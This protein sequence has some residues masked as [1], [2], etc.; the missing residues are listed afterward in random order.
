MG[1]LLTRTLEERNCVR[2]YG[3]RC[4]RLLLVCVCCCYPACWGTLCRC[5]DPLGSDTSS[6]TRSSVTGFICVTRR[7]IWQLN[8]SARMVWCMNPS[9]SSVDFLS[10]L[11]ALALEELS[12]R[13]PSLLET[14][15]V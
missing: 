11:T 5:A 1:Q 10:K 8:F 14:A 4:S 9:A 7:E 12:F 6:P 15:S 13:S 3:A 2:F